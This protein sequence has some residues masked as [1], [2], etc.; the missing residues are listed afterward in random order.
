M[1]ISD[2]RDRFFYPQHTPMKDTY[3]LIPTDDRQKRETKDLTMILVRCTMGEICLMK[4]TKKLTRSPC[5]DTSCLS[6]TCTHEDRYN[7]VVE[8]GKYI[9]REFCVYDKQQVYPEYVIT[10][11]RVKV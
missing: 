2:P 7:S 9:F 4:D 3:F 8:E 1:P 5:K 10:Y 6:D 11:D